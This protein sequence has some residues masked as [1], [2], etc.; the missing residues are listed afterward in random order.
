MAEVNRCFGWQGTQGGFVS[1]VLTP[2]FDAIRAQDPAAKIV[3]PGL[4]NATNFND[5]IAYEKNHK[6]YLWRAFDFIAIHAYGE[7]GANKG[8]IDQAAQYNVCTEDG[9]CP[10]G[11]WI[12]EYG[13][14]KDDDSFSNPNCKNRERS[15]DPGGEALA[16]LQHCLDTPKCKKAFYWNLNEKDDFCGLGVID[17]AGAVRPEY[18]G[19]LNFMKANPVDRP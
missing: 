13:N 1:K 11:F 12:T 8:W 5:W 19:F 18:Q 3:A 4:H 14:F 17:G 2:A 10:A 6:H 9:H 16:T 15:P 7:V